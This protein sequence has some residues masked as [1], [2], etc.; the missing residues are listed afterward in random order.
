MGTVPGE[1]SPIPVKEEEVAKA[2][3]QHPHHLLP[4]SL[5]LLAEIEINN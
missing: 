2:D 5:P 4:D 3:Q 1:A